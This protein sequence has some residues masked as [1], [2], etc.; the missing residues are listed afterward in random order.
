MAEIFIGL[1]VG[2]VLGAVFAARALG[3]IVN[4]GLKAWERTGDY[5]RRK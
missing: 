5:I 3:P 1:L 4:P 2:F